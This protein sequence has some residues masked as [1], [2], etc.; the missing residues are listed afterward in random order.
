MAAENRRHTRLAAGTEIVFCSAFPLV[1][2]F[3]TVATFS[4]LGASTFAIAGVVVVAALSVSLSSTAVVVVLVLAVD[5]VP[6]TSAAGVFA[7]CSTMNG[8]TR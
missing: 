8:R 7:R 1:S 6:L 2:V 3:S 4:T 5:C